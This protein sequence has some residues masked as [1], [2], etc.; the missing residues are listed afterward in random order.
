MQTGLDA[1][2]GMHLS[3]PLPFPN[4][5]DQAP[6]GITPLDLPMNEISRGSSSAMFKH[7]IDI[8]WNVPAPDKTRIKALVKEGKWS[9]LPVPFGFKSEL[10]MK[11]LVQFVVVP[12]VNG[13]KFTMVKRVRSPD[14][15]LTKVVID[16]LCHGTPHTIRWQ[17][18][19][20]EGRKAWQWFLEQ[21]GGWQCRQYALTQVL[22][23]QQ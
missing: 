22:P 8:V 17:G 9:S 19:A 10:E 7:F 23:H 3:R 1:T 12:Q 11:V 4:W 2:Q 18:S 6:G 5:V 13:H 14:L 16:T 21:M 20:I 15:K